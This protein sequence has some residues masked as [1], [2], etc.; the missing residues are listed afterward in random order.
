M[1]IRL[2]TFGFI[3]FLP[4]LTTQW[5]TIVLPQ[6]LVNNLGISDPSHTSL[7][8]GYFYISFF[9]GR[10]LGTFVWP[11]MVKVVN[12]KICILL[13]IIVMG[14]MNA[15]S[16]IGM[17]IFVICFCRFIAGIALNI[18]TVGKD[19]LFEF[20]DENY[21]Q[22][23]LSIDSAFGLMGNLL[24]PYIGFYLYNKFDH[25][26]DQTVLFIAF[27]FFI[28]FVLFFHVFFITYT[29]PLN[30]SHT[31]EEMQKMLGEHNEKIESTG[32]KGTILSF[33]KN[34]SIRSLILVYGLGMACTNSDLVISVLYLQ[35]DWK[36]YG[37]GI[38]SRALSHLSMFCYIPALFLLFLS[39]KMVPRY[40]SY[41]NYIR[42][43]FT[44]FALAVFL[45]PLLR[46]ILPKEN[47]S[48]YNFIIYIV[49]GLKYCFNTHM[50]APFIHY[51]INK[52][53]KREARTIVN[54]LN[55]ITATIMICVVMNIITPLLSISMYKQFFKEREPYSKDLTFFMIT[56][57]MLF[58]VFLLTYSQRK[59]EIKKQ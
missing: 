51:L 57:L 32:I 49:Q 33:F 29:P 56:A 25:S 44:I 58:S 45:T 8:A 12:K 28:G 26:F 19:F 21:R 50:S 35:M 5:S 20:C 22:I 27:L 16:G 18:H 36:D 30:V 38:S 52:R 46:D 3:N 34:S 41:M 31:D 23:G 55:F 53:A 4:I 15:L 24:G 17:K 1:I 59:A 48:R 39:N 7:I 43:V 42:S 14:L 2:S 40:I 47:H 10:L 54:S 13:S 37:L 11:L 6:I 9:Y